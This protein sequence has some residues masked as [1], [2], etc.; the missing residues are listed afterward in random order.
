MT[1]PR[2]TLDGGGKFIILSL[3]QEP[4]TPSLFSTPGPTCLS[5]HKTVDIEWETRMCHHT[6]PL[7]CKYKSQL[8]AHVFLVLPACPTPLLG[9]DLMYELGS[10]FAL[11]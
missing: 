2:G 10:R 7:T 4:L 9:G 3:I 5:D 8:V 1:E 6:M 11:Y